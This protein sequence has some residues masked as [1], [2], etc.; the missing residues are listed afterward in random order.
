MGGKQLGVGDYEQTTS[1]KCTKSEK[2]MDDMEHMVP[3]TTR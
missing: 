2:F 3:C 1:K